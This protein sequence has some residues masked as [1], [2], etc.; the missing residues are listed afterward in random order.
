MRHIT[1]ARA[2]E[3]T[4][5]T[6][7]FVALADCAPLVAAVELGLFAKQGLDVRLQRQASWAA[8]RDNVAI[9]RLDGAQML[10]G[11]PLAATLGHGTAPVPMLTGLA[12]G[13]NGNSITLDAGLSQRMAELDVGRP[14]SAPASAETLARV[15]A[16]DRDAGLAPMT[17]AMVHPVSSHHY[18]LRYWLASGGLDPDRDVRLIVVPPARMLAN[19]RAGRIAGYCVGAPWSEA[20]VAEGIGHVAITGH[21]LWNNAPEK[22][23]GVARDWAEVYPNTH[24]A[25][26]CA[27]LEACIWLDEPKHRERIA[28]HVAGAGFV[29]CDAAQL[30]AVY[31]GHIRRQREAAIEWHP[32]HLVFARHQS[33]FPWRSHAVWF[34]RQMQRW[35]Q[36]HPATDVHAVAA[37]V[38]R[39]E[40]YREVCAELERPA[41]VVD[42]KTEGR[43]G[44]AW[45][46]VT[47]GADITLGP[48][49]FFDGG[50][51]DPMV[52]APRV[53][54]AG[55][56]RAHIL[57]GGLQ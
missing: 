30:A 1:S 8:I 39:P 35:G 9:G 19:L 2:L 54:G 48:D 25:V 55:P 26:L 12:L 20:A 10:A 57:E 15:V 21:E 23:F 47:L 14:G 40:L 37:A 43:H 28:P 44:Q 27:L 46:D 41:P 7:G 29:D 31:A 33:N 52:A 32:D 16:A 5:L 18:Q 45:S 42:Y 50:T 3:K 6:L 49:R 24:R 56:S 13:A 4:R 51:F 17:F 22:V 11:L 53:H 36:L 34:L 38:Y